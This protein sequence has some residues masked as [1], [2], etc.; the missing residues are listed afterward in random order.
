MVSAEDEGKFL[1][2]PNDSNTFSPIPESRWNAL[3][4]GTHDFLENLGGILDSAQVVI[5]V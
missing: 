3:V 4:R 1:V 2:T 5:T